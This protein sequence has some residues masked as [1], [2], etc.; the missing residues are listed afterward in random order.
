MLKY[1]SLL[2]QVNA[3]SIKSMQDDH[4]TKNINDIT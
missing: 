4:K 3:V 2:I 1:L